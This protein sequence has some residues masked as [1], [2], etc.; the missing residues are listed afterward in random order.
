MECVTSPGQPEFLSGPVLLLGAPGVGKGT[1]AQIL[2]Q[3]WGVPQIST[4]DI[5][6]ANIKGGSEMGKE[7]QKLVSAG[8]LVPDDLVNQMVAERLEQPDTARGYLLD[9]FPRTLPQA[10]WLDGHL[11]TNPSGLPVVA[12][13]IEVGY[14]QL[15]GRITGRRTC[16]VCQTIYNVHFNPPK[17][18]G[19]C[20]KEGAALEQRAD[21][22]EEKFAERMRVFD[23]QT[24]PVIEHY[25]ALGRFEAV[26][27]DHPVEVVTEKIV[28]AL[29]RL[30]GN[31]GQ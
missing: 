21:D 18:E 31:E 8:H 19:K 28:A 7:F 5:I 17:V 10:E 23:T 14:T 15:L 29:M 1:Q 4:G 12:V 30:R 22:T 20:D 25:R 9:G 2:M 24:A 3:A 26:D 6:R 16:P 11:G 13:S 27:G